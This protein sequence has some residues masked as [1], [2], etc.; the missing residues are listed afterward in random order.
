M[1]RVVMGAE[2]PFFLHFPPLFANSIQLMF[3]AICMLMYVISSI[4][5]WGLIHVPYHVHTPFQ[6]ALYK[7][8]PTDYK[9]SEYNNCFT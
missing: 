9:S 6:M 3:P 2:I 8:Y 5:Y 4:C 7:P 1:I